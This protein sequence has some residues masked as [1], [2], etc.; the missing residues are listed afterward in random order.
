MSTSNS[1]VLL[2]HDESSHKVTI[3]GIEEDKDGGLTAIVEVLMSTVAHDLSV[4]TVKPVESISKYEN[5]IVVEIPDSTGMID[6][7]SLRIGRSSISCTYT[8]KVSIQVFDDS[9]E[10]VTVTVVTPN[11]SG[12]NT[13]LISS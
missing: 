7:N 12:D 11:F 2:T 13:S 5:E 8:K 9:S 3:I 10:T 4:V 6:G 1:I